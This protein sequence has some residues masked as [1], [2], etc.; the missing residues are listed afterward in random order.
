MTQPPS[1]MFDASLATYGQTPSATVVHPDWFLLHD[2]NQDI[3]RGQRNSAE[4]D[5]LLIGGRA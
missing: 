3:Q 4:W 2:G 5:V 1:I